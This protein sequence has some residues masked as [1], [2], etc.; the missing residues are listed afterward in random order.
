[1]ATVHGIMSSYFGDYEYDVGKS[2]RWFQYFCD[3]EY[4]LDI[5]GGE[6]T[7]NLMVAWA[8]SFPG[9]KFSYNT[10]FPF[11]QSPAKA[12]EWR[13]L[14][15]ERAKAA[16]KNYDPEDWVLF[17]D[18]SEGLCVDDTV[19]AAG[20]NPVVPEDD[21]DPETLVIPQN[22]G[23]V[24]EFKS[25]VEYEISQAQGAEQDVDT[26]FLPTWIY[27]NE[28][29]PYEVHITI[30]SVIAAQLAEA[31][32][33]GGYGNVIDG[34]TNGEIERLNTAMN[35]T[36]QTEYAFAGYLPRLIKVSKLESFLDVSVD[37]SDWESLD[38]WVAHPFSGGVLDAA[39]TETCSIISYAYAQWSDDPTKMTW[40]RLPE[41]EESDRGWYTRNLISNIR[42][43]PGLATTVNG[44]TWA[45]STAGGGSEVVADRFWGWQPDELLITE[46]TNDTNANVGPEFENSD[47]G[48]Q[49]QFSGDFLIFDKE[50]ITDHS[51]DTAGTPNQS[52]WFPGLPELRT[53]LYDNMFRDNI[54]DGLF[55][56]D[57]ELGPVPWNFVAGAP[58]V[59]PAEWDTQL[60]R[61]DH[62]IV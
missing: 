48:T 44:D 31:D 60:E 52:N 1:M 18:V 5:N 25:Y 28:T 6:K 3:D 59:P 10:A 38:D 50:P 17:I 45:D 34:F 2:M 30:D 42:P 13:Q 54:R 20:F 57:K 4:V 12:A 62:N 27:L 16:W 53:P 37:S 41:T 15:Y 24:N 21:S 19:T 61:R 33:A 58:A 14:S 7:R 8:E 55:Y 36:T 23:A 29:A 11:F 43:V 9:V 47:T 51:A 39:P 22:L 40:D 46:A 56:F 49:D 26:I 32:L 35:T